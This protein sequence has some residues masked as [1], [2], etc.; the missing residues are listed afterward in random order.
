MIRK[1]SSR[2]RRRRTL[3]AVAA[4]LLLALIAG[5]PG[6]AGATM[7]GPCTAQVHGQDVSRLSASD[8]GKA[9][10]VDEADTIAVAS[11]STSSIGGYRIQLEY[12]GIRWTV[13]KGQST[14]N[15]WSRE[16]KVSDYARYGAGVYRVHGVSDGAASCDGAVLI[17]V[18]GNP[19]TSLVGIIALIFVA[20]GVINAIA[21]LRFRPGGAVE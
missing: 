3:A 2:T 18:G 8:T 15:Q 19:L 10:K 14:N 17:D 20:I 9:I 11:Q 5:A 13:A 12:F 6:V 16:V 7:S 4:T 1:H 21:T